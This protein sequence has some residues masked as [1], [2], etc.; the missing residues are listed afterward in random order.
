MIGSISYDD[1]L[2]FAASLENSSKNIRQVIE[3]YTSEKVTRVGEF[4][5]CIDTYIRFINSYIQLYKDS[6][7]ALKYIIEKNK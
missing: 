5:D 6:D 4:C 2:K 3:K 1:M 7:E